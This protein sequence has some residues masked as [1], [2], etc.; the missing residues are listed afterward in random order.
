M[1]LIAVQ[2]LCLVYSFS[3]C[4]FLFSYKGFDRNLLDH[5][6]NTVSEPNVTSVRNKF[7][8]ETFCIIRKLFSSEVLSLS[9]LF[10]SPPP[11]C[12]AFPGQFPYSSNSFYSI[13]LGNLANTTLSANTLWIIAQN[14]ILTWMVD[15]MIHILDLRWSAKNILIIPWY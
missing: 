1:L 12:N 13:C 11:G 8:T 10:P 14:F 4:F 9:L 3:G 5:V 2:I 15:F 7:S 6:R